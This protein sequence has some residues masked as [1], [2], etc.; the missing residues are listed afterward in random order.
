MSFYGFGGKAPDDSS[1][2][3]IRVFLFRFYFFFLHRNQ[4]EKVNKE[5]YEILRQCALAL[6]GYGSAFILELVQPQYDLY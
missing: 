2:L 6:N 5:N 4:K 1:H 3:I